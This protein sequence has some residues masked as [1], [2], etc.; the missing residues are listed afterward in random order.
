MK[1]Y[2]LDLVAATFIILD[3]NEASMQVSLSP[4]R[5]EIKIE[6][7]KCFRL[8]A[9]GRSASGTRSTWSARC[10]AARSRNQ[11]QKTR[12]ENGRKKKRKGAVS[13]KQKHRKWCH[14]SVY[15]I[16]QCNTSS[17]LF[18]S[19]SGCQPSETEG[20][21]LVFRNNSVLALNKVTI[22]NSLC[23]KSMG[24]SISNQQEN[25]PT[26]SRRLVM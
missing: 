17:A 12:T 24:S 20:C 9:S 26:C 11:K 22:N 8:L 2:N 21:L 15:D 16:N 13:Q 18:E 4:K 5:L 25:N 3:S 10:S 7:K 23:F 1:K 19:A 6:N 14:L